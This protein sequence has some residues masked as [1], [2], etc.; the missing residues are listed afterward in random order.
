LGFSCSSQRVLRCRPLSIPYFN[1]N[2]KNTIGEKDSVVAIIVLMLLLFILFKNRGWVYLAF[3][4]AVISLMSPHATYYLHRVWTFLT[5]ILGRFSGSII[6]FFVFIFIL[7]PTAILKKWFGKKEIILS[8]KNIHSVFEN[9]N[10]R[11]TK[12]DFDNPW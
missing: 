7:I 5:E 3:A 9:R 11:Y 8:N 10:H 12:T 4:I 6:L 2:K 1:M